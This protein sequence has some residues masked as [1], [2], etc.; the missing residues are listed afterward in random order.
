MALTAELVA[1]CH[2]E[3]DDPG[4]PADLVQLTDAEYVAAA[5]R[6]LGELGPDPFWLFAYGS[7]IWKPAFEPA[8]H[9]R[10]TARGW[11]RAFTMH[12]TRW[13]GTTAQPG[14]MMVLEPGGFCTGVAYCLPDRER[15]DQIV[16]LLRR[17]TASHEGLAAVRWIT[18]DTAEGRLRALS[19]W[20]GI[21]AAL[22]APNQDHAG[23]A[24]TLVRACGHL[25]SG[26]DYLYRTVSK[27]E[28]HGIRDRA[29]WTL[30]E[31]V[32]AEILRLHGSPGAATA[33]IPAG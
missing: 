30:Q 16:R 33:V 5:E 19:F 21:T 24:A 2:R 25:G 9:L 18:V 12:L 23:V 11:H 31:L 20:T 29:L 17:E 4:P 1:R 28:E 3:E 8:R 14:L 22:R 6:L 10:G 15:R 32:A 13:R 27:L 7:L 26:A